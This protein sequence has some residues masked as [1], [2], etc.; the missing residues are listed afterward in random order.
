MAAKI[1]THVAR[2]TTSSVMAS[3]CTQR[4]LWGVE[5]LCVTVLASEMCVSICVT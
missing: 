2:P 5:H 3:E 1:P 4:T